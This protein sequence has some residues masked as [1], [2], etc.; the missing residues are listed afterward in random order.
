M[1]NESEDNTSPGGWSRLIELVSCG[2]ALDSG[3]DSGVITGVLGEVSARM[4]F[5]TA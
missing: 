2:A 5:A 4:A 3:N 1:A